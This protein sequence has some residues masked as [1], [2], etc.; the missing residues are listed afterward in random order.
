MASQV[1]IPQNIVQVVFKYVN[2]VCISSGR[3][4]KA[5]ER[6]TLII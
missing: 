2:H 3:F 5:G 6:Y 4:T 1:Q